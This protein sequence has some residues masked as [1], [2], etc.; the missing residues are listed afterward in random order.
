MQIWRVHGRRELLRRSRPHTLFTFAVFPIAALAWF[1]G[2][3]LCWIGEC[4]LLRIRQ[5]RLGGD[6]KNG[7]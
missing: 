7:E 4:K 3:S 6:C 2:W 5:A 1:V